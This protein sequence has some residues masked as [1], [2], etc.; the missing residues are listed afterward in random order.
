MR[1]Q[2]KCQC[3]QK[4]YSPERFLAHKRATPCRIWYLENA[5][6]AVASYQRDVA[7]F[8]RQ[9]DSALAG[10]ALRQ[11]ELAELEGKPIPEA[12]GRIPADDIDEE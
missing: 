8:K 3:G 4:F 7:Y 2:L 12:V 10:L 5:R 11:A 6:N 9:L 1:T